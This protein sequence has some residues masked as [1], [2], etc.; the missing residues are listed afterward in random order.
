MN[1]VND[2]KTHGIIDGIGAV[3]ALTV[4]AVYAFTVIAPY[5]IQTPTNVAVLEIVKSNKS[6]V[7]LI[8]TAVVMFFFGASVQRRKDQDTMGTLVKT[9]AAQVAALAPLAG[10]PGADT[11]VIPSDTTATVTP[12]DDGA[13]IHKEP[14][15]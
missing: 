4:M 3:V 5:M 13:V 11:M 8:T 1:L 7:D 12:T 6:T 14:N 2:E 15:P 10:A 9:N